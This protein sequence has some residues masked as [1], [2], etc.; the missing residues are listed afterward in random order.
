MFSSAN[1]DSDRDV[2]TSRMV[3]PVRYRLL[4]AV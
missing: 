2:L 4:T 1:W 3:G